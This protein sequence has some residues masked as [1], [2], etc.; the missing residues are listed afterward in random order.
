MMRVN[1]FIYEE[2]GVKCFHF[3]F[4]L[5]ANHLQKTNQ[6]VLKQSMCW[7]LPLAS[8]RVNDVWLVF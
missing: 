2:I 3:V 1:F 8:L 6:T 7:K 5:L 4:I